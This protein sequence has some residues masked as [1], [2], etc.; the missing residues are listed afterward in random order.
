[1]IHFVVCA[2][3]LPISLDYTH[4]CMKCI[5]LLQSLSI[6]RKLR[7]Q[8]FET[9]SGLRH[10]FVYIFIL[11]QER[12]QEVGATLETAQLVAVSTSK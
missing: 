3:G 9:V 2:G 7:H 12:S 6:A 5:L 11:M 10:N 4:T 8:Y 1:M